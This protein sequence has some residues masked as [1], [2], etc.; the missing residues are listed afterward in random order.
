MFEQNQVLVLDVGHGFPQTDVRALGGEE[1]N[2]N[3]DDDDGQVILH[4]LFDRLRV[5]HMAV[6]KVYISCG[7]LQ[8]FGWDVS[9]RCRPDVTFDVVHGHGPQEQ[10]VD[11]CSFQNSY[12]AFLGQM[13]KLIQTF[14]KFDKPQHR[15]T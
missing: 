6:M 9:P 5:A 4:H 2:N 15:N 7:V 8:D 11:P 1:H 12:L 10:D 14:S 13:S 3:H